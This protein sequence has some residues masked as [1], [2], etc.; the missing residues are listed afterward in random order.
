MRKTLRDILIS[1]IILVVATALV[2]NY[3]DINIFL[4]WVKIY[5][6]LGLLNLYTMYKYN[7]SYRVVY[8]PLAPLTFIAFYSLGEKTTNIILNNT[9]SLLTPEYSEYIKLTL[10]RIFSKLPLVLMVYLTA[11]LLYRK[12]RN[13][14]IIKWWFYNIPLILA[15]ATYQFD[16][17]MV[18]FLL[19]GTYLLLEDKLLYAGISWG[20]GS[21]I[22]QVPII[23][24]PIIYRYL[25]DR[26]KFIKFLLSFALTILVISLPFMLIDP[27]GFINN[28]LGFHED[29]PP[30]YLSV[31]NIPVLLSGRDP[32]V[33]NIVISIWPYI[34]LPI[35]ILTLLT[36]K[37]KPKDKDLLFK[38]ILA[39][40]LVFTVFNKVVNPNYLLWAY[41]YA[42]YVLLKN[43][44]K[45]GLKLL[46]IASVIAM[47]WPG[48]CFYTAAVLNKPVYI[49]E[50]MKY[51]DA[52]TLVE[53]SFQGYGRIIL[54]L[55][56]TIG[57]MIKPFIQFIYDNL[58]IIGVI[59]ISSY[60]GIMI[61]VLFYDVYYI[62]GFNDLKSKVMN[63][64][65]HIKSAVLVSIEK[66]HQK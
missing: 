23:L 37:I 52:R 19:L 11:Y 7:Q 13:H 29:R 63:G 6:E 18:F 58:N 61:Y 44:D 54:Q 3:Y 1:T 16:P 35:Y 66:Y 50:E 41:P 39:I 34:F 60:T 26:S 9:I 2:W 24:L 45:R 64:V 36:L 46:I 33:T 65:K 22:K 25:R 38:S 32:Q 47:S 30:Q 31:F 48:I 51:Y 55:A 28:A 62:R 4:N 42:I 53:K 15:V 12:E 43:R 27:I 49:E 56:L 59:L 57:Y 21:A 8:L 5:N 17:I 20:I 40:L 10:I 14:E